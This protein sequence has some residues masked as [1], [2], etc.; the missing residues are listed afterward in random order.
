[1][2]KAKTKLIKVK[3]ARGTAKAL[4]FLNSNIVNKAPK[5]Q[6]INHIGIKIKSATLTGSNV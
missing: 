4:L 2:N 1:M 5:A 6:T 3:P